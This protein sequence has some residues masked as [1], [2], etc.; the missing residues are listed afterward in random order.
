LGKVCLKQSS[1]NPNESLFFEIFMGIH[2]LE[3]LGNFCS[4]LEISLFIKGNWECA[5]KGQIKEN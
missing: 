3:P 2:V 1:D 5:N 4:G